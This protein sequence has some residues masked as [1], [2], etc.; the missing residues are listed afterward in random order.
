MGYTMFRFRMQKEQ[1][2]YMF[3]YIA[4]TNFDSFMYRDL[5]KYFVE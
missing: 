1:P 3:V 2:M 4:Y 5:T